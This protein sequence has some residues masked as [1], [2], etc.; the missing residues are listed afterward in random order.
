ML[1]VLFSLAV[2]VTFCDATCRVIPLKI[3]LDGEPQGCKDEHGAMHDFDSEWKANCEKCTCD[4]T[5]IQC[6][7]T[8]MK[9][10]EY[11]KVKC[12]AI[13]DKASCH[14]NVVEKANP[15]VEC[16]VTAYTS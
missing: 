4:K 16:E 15:S 7:N 12:H 13:F 8:F 6:C 11:D 3:T 5:G 10:V 9:P 1:R 2:L 14:Y